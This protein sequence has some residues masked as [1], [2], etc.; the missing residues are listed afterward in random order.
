MHTPFALFFQG[1]ALEYLL[2]AVQIAL[3]EDGPDLTSRAVFSPADTMRAEIVAKEDILPAGLPIAELVLKEAAKLEPGAWELTTH[4]KDGVFLRKGAK[5]L[6][7]EGGT[8]LLLRS[9]RVILNFL[10]HLS[11][12]AG[13]TARY[14]KALSGTGLTTFLQS[15]TK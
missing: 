9:E 3:E 6:T 2:R 4:A 14:V 13:L 15:V 10:C 11:G 5:A 12:I 8:R 1:K 7:L